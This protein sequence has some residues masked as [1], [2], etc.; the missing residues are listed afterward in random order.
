MELVYY[1]INKDSCINEQGFC[2][3]PEYSISMLKSKE[4][5]YEVRLEKKKNYQYFCI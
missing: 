1:W 5:I 4:G 3:S 2:F